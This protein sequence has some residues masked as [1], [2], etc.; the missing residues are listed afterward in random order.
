MYKFL[1]ILHV[2]TSS[3][4][5]VVA[6]AVTSRS[7]VGWSKNLKYT[8][9]DRY[10]AYLFMVLLYLTLVHGIIMYF[11]IDP[12]SKSAMDIHHAIKQVSLRFWVVEH[13]YFMTFALIL[14][15]I[16]GIFIRKTTI[17]KNRFAYASFYYG[18]ATLITIVSVTFYFIY[19]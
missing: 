8:K 1:I 18:V 5:L 17:D 16:G 14:S 7:I 15:Q 6:I 2:I 10:V 12:S 19:R 11:F 13:F 4:F 9:T 3:V